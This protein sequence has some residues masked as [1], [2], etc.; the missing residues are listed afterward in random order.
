M[1]VSPAGPV[2]NDKEMTLAEI[3]AGMRGRR[4][5]DFEIVP[6][7]RFL[8]LESRATYRSEIWEN[9]EDISALSEKITL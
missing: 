9:C 7:G 2:A 3:A 6:V 1:T 4:E 8:F 5:A